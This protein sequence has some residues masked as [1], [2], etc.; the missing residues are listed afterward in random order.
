MSTDECFFSSENP[1]ELPR[2]YFYIKPSMIGQEK[3][4]KL[5]VKIKAKKMVKIKAKKMV[6][7]KAKK[8]NQHLI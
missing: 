4:K 8:N 7:I 6:K 3:R 5:G 2:S 1:F